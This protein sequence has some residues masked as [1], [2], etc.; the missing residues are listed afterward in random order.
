ML[1]D[2]RHLHFAQRGPPKDMAGG[3]FPHPPV[4]PSPALLWL[5]QRRSRLATSLVNP[6]CGCSPGSDCPDTFPDGDDE[7]ALT[8]TESVFRQESHGELSRTTPG[9][10]RLIGGG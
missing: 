10:K 6:P 1:A 4:A 2:E 5:Q 3:E 8:D 9:G 7:R